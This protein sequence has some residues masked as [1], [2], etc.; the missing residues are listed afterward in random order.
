MFIGSYYVWNNIIPSDTIDGPV[1]L[2]V[3]LN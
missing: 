2:I 1:V 3:N